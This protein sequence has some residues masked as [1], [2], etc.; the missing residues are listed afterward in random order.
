MPSLFGQ[1]AWNK[2][3]WFFHVKV[4]SRRFTSA[5]GDGQQPCRRNSRQMAVD[6]IIEDD[7]IDVSLRTFYDKYAGRR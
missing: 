4:V 6:Y 3:S 1:R 5:A 2:A 7:V